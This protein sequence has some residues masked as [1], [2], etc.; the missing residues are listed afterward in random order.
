MSDIDPP[1]PSVA[2]TVEQ[3]LHQAVAHHKA[4][5]LQE[6]ESLY[7]A[8][9]QVQPN[10]PDANHNLGVLAV[11]VKQPAAGLPHFKLALEADPSQ[12]QYSLS[13]ADALLATGQAKDALNIIQVAMR[14]GLDTPA[15]RTLLQRSE[16]AVRNAQAGVSLAELLRSGKTIQNKGGQLNN[17]NR[18]K[19]KPPS[20]QWLPKAEIDQLLELFNA[21]RHAELEDRARTLLGHY[22][23]SGYVWHVLGVSLQEQGKD[24]LAALQKATELMPD[25]ANAHSNL[26]IALNFVGRHRDAA[27]S[28]RRALAIKPDFAAASCALGA[29]LQGQGKPEE[30]M[31]SYRRALEIRPNDADARYGLG[32]VL[33]ETGRFAEGWLEYEYRWE[34]AWPKKGRPATP[35]PQWAGQDPSGGD[36]LLVF[37]EQGMGDILQFS[38][39]LLLLAHRFG[40]RLSLVLARPLQTLLRRSFP[41]VEML[42]AVPVDQSAWRWQCPLLS[43]PLAFG[44]T[45]DNIPGPVPYLVPDAMRVAYWKSRIE[46]LDL[47]AAARRIGVVWKTGKA[48]KNATLRSLTLQQLAPLLNQPGTAWFSL[49]KEAD[50]DSSQWADA[51]VLVDWAGELRDFD[52]T[53]ALL[54]NMDLVVSVDT[55]VAHL[56]GGLGRPIWLFN[57]HASEWRWMR[58]REGS[59]WYPTMRIFTQQAAGDWDEVVKRMSVELRKPA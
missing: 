37:T 24:A 52:D 41:G 25:D 47:P 43:L 8:I 29:A 53:A 33:L 54:M 15:A 28:C 5:Q 56:A 44:T 21:R 31:A 40:D 7:R 1:Q 30:A 38:R 18:S 57:R 20:Q 10:Q 42:E 48:M 36:R 22:P 26:A 12:G 49:Q 39:Y 14:R 16:A 45:L 2:L 55:S 50:P 9:L 23:R 27:A 19:G 17:G 4:G 13:Y 59:P 11:D 46:A 51:G 35:L 58:H 6:A 3:A 32:L 34:G